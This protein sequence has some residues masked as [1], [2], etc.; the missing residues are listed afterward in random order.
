MIPF[1]ALSRN[2]QSVMSAWA[3]DT[4][5][6]PDW[7]FSSE[8]TFVTSIEA[9]SAARSPVNPP[10]IVR[11]DTV[12]RTALSTRTTVSTPDHMHYPVARM[13]IEM[14]MHVYVQKPLTHSVWEAR[15]LA[16]LARRHQVATQMGNQ[17]QASEEVRVLCEFLWD[18][19]IGPVH[20]VHVWSN[21]P[22]WPQ[23]V[24]R[25]SDVHEVPDSLDWDLWLG[26]APERPFGD[27]GR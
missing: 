7:A 10:R 9:L 26:V 12:T 21:R 15:Q 25:P 17:G 27:A 1:S 4:T 18:G 24:E 3:L 23:G 6:K 11:L 13:A 22:I 14:G 19:A 5:A 16:V 20:E 2:V 8:V